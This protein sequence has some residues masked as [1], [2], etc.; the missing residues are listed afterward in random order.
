MFSFSQSS[1]YFYDIERLD[2]GIK[3]KTQK[4]WVNK[5]KFY[6]N[7][8][9]NPANVIAQEDGIYTFNHLRRI[10]YSIYLEHSPRYYYDLWAKDDPETWVY[11]KDNSG[12]TYGNGRDI[13]DQGHFIFELIVNN[14]FISTWRRP[15]LK[16]GFF[17]YTYF[18]SDIWEYV[19]FTND[20]DGNNF[21]YMDCER[22]Q[23][24]LY[25]YFVNDPKV[26]T[27]KVE[28]KVYL[29]K[30]KAEK[31]ED[32]HPNVLAKGTFN[33]VLSEKVVQNLKQNGQKKTTAFTFNKYV[34]KR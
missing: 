24:P 34:F 33:M 7:V 10:D 18:K 16:R 3:S 1:R 27:Y 31:P 2:E 23:N 20:A 29:A 14:K 22:C 13:P 11:D 30:P 15:I 8:E 21:K 32:K 17:E 19:E 5:I 9:N 6:P 26:G 25:N 12:A 4:E 28:L